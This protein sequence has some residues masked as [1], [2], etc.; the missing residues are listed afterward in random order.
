MVAAL[1]PVPACVLFAVAVPV[2]SGRICSSV[3]GFSRMM[4]NVH[5]PPAFF[6]RFPEK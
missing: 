4:P 6:G 3:P 5:L 1:P 2:A